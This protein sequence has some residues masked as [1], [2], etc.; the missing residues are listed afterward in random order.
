MSK[1]L[2]INSVCGS[3]STGRICTDLYDLAEKKGHK[4]YIAYGRGNAPESYNTIK[5]G[6]K[7]DLFSHVFFSRVFDRHGFASKKA[8]KKFIQKIED[9]NPDI[10]HLHNLHGYYV[11]IRLL[12][13]YFKKNPNIQIIWTLHDCWS[14]TGHC[15]YFTY[16]KCYKW[17]NNECQNCQYKNKYPQ[18]YLLNNSHSN[19]ILKK[20]LFNQVPNLTLVTPSKWLASLV[21]ISYL[22]TY[23]TLVINNGIDINKFKQNKYD[24]NSISNYSNYNKIILGVANGFGERKGLDWFI[25]LRSDLPLEIAIVLVGVDKKD[26]TFIP[27]DIITI[28]KTNN[29]DELVELYSKADVFVNPTREDNYPT[30]NLEAQACGTPV[31]TTNVGGSPETI[32]NTTGL[33]AENYDQFLKYIKD[34]LN[35]KYKFN[36]TSIN[37]KVD[38]YL[39]FDKYIELYERIRNEDINNRF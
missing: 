30:V 38:R 31:I 35:N 12:F 29:I 37:Q 27:S 22:K 4:C 23:R 8:T 21:K 17:I 25:K 39:L 1:I 26:K 15:T 18:S 11:N 36:F 28:D 9:I 14:F 19:Y 6:N 33:V 16:S 5:I 7:L 20:H 2:F 10:I 3:G 34:V 32:F 24:N 13:N